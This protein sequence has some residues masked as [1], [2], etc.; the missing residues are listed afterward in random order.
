[1]VLLVIKADDKVKKIHNNALSDYII[2]K[3]E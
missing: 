1:M 2:I 3:G